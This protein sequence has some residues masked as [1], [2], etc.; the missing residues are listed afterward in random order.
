M[1]REVLNQQSY[2]S[3][4]EKLVTKISNSVSTMTI[5][6]YNEAF[7]FFKEELTSLSERYPDIFFTEKSGDQ[8]LL[9]GFQA[10]EKRYEAY[11]SERQLYIHFYT[12][13]S[14]KRIKI[15]IGGLFNIYKF[16]ELDNSFG[17]K[18]VEEANGEDNFGLVG[19]PI[20]NS[21]VVTLLDK[22]SGPIDSL[23]F[24]AAE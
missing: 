15:N 1:N 21:L 13:G 16:D 10:D 7:I 23:I 19:L 18:L 20:N 3:L 4:E 17:F 2:E 22:L 24:G 6:S 14:N 11:E 8:E 9:F 5:T 12:N